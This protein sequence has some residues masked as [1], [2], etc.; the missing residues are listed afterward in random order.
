[1]RL[2]IDDLSTRWSADKDFLI[3][4]LIESCKC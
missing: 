3:F 1:V 2:R 4:S